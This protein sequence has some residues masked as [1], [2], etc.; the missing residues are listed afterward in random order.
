V[1][2]L[3]TG[4]FVHAVA[5]MGDVSALVTAHGNY[6]PKQKHVIHVSVFN[7]LLNFLRYSER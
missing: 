7:F 2:G 1:I 6:T 3:I 5:V 4:C